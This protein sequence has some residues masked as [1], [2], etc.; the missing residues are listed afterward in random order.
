MLETGEADKGI[1][2]FHNFQNL[3]SINL[4]IEEVDKTDTSL[5]NVLALAK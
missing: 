2:F 5:G 3:S 4:P 1:Q